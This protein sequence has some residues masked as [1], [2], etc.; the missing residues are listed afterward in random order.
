MTLIDRTE[1]WGQHG[2][3]S[4]RLISD[5]SPPVRM[6]LHDIRQSL[7]TIRLIA[8]ATATHPDVPPQI[9]RWSREIDEQGRWVAQL[10][11]RLDG[12]AAA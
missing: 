7:A 8:D 11:R 9:S 12:A 10:I 6:L 4:G 1:D 3:A 5:V 2:G